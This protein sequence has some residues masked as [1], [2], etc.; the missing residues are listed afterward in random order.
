MNIKKIEQSI[1]SMEKILK[2]NDLIFPLKRYLPYCEPQLEKEILST[3]NSQKKIN[4]N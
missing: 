2:V 1:E 3:I 4:Q